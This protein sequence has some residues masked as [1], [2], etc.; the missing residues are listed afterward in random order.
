M[1]AFL[2]VSI[3]KKLSKCFNVNL[4]IGQY[5]ILDLTYGAKANSR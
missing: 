2:K 5:L 1:Y 4:G 3:K